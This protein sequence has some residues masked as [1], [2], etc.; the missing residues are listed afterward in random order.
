MDNNLNWDKFEKEIANNHYYYAR[1]CIRQNFFPGAEEIFINILRNNLK[2]DIYD[3]PK[4]TTCTGIGYHSSIIPLETTMTVIARQFSLMNEAG[5]QNFVCSC[6]TSFGLYLEVLSTWHHFP[7]TLEKTKKYLKE[8]TGRTFELPKNLVH[9][10]DIIYKFRNELASMIKYKLIN[11]KTQEPLNVVEH[12]GCH[13]AKIFPESGI[14]GAEYPRVLS[15]IIE[16]WGGRV[17]DY[18]ERRHC[19]GFGFRQ[20]LVK[21]NRG[22]SYSHS[23]KKLES[24]KPYKVDLIITNCPGCNYFLD[25][26]QYVAAVNENKLFGRDNKAIPVLTFEE[27]TAILL[28]YNPWKVGLQMHQIPVEPLLDKL[29]ISY[30]KEEKYFKTK[31]PKIPTILNY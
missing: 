22:Y 30:S 1:S 4:H 18:P 17:I 24:M 31:A 7:E 28:G 27:L 8:A 3:D 26:W 10:S 15:G 25:R 20:Y 11:F 16:T 9:A 29:G 23:L 12:V 19:C 2:K 14:G 13:Y 6:V 21:S 5:Y